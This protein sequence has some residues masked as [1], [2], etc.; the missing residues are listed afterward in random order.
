M[1]QTGTIGIVGGGQL[2]RMLT[3]AALPLGFKVTVID[4]GQNCPAAQVGAEQIR[5][6]FYDAAAI[7]ELAERSDYLTIE[8][9]HVNTEILQAL[10]AGGQPVNP[11]PQTVAMI[12]DKYRQKVFLREAGVPVAD[13]VE[14]TDEASA[15]Q[16][17]EVFGGKMLLK[18]R[19]GAYDGRG[20]ALI[21]KPE[22]LSAAMRS[23][24]AKLYAEKFVPF[25]KE[26]A[27]M[28]ARDG[29]GRTACYPVTETVHERN[30][31]IE[32]FT[33]A[34]VPAA[35]AKRAEEV[36]L[37]VAK[38]LGGAGVF[39]IEMFLTAAGDILVNEIAP[40]VHNSGHYTIEACETSQFEQHVRAVSG[41]S[42]GSTKLKVPAAVMVNILG[43][44]DGPTRVQG[45]DE[46]Q[47]VPGVTVNLYGKS[48][49]KIDRKMG[50]ITAVADSLPEARR[51]AEQARKLIDI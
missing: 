7:R 14:V 17:L 32:T 5:A 40:R 28:V 16:A 41:L 47:A 3:E 42:L 13:F 48:P 45:L 30:I 49:T 31:C 18:S 37:S 9:E 4:P 44:H 23:L 39:G 27:V 36:A 15:R 25:V 50:H 2:G 11:A 20:N 33:P 19:L 29:R 34:G 51:H 43:E 26:L 8:T 35:A 21:E 10:A 12:Q 22:D 24:G 6:D 1:D 38:H 46:A